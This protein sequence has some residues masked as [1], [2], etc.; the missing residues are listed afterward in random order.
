VLGQQKDPPRQFARKTFSHV[1]TRTELFDKPFETIS[2]AF[3]VFAASARRFCIEC[4][5]RPRRVLR[6][7][8]DRGGLVFSK[9][10][11]P[12]LKLGSDAE[13]HCRIAQGT[14]DVLTG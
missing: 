5:A 14:R 8:S 7:L 2:N 4:A 13:K 9:E 11:L 3:A 6:A 1:L 12:S 10:F